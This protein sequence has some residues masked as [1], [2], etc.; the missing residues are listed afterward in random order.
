[1]LRIN[2]SIALDVELNGNGTGKHGFQPGDPQTGR[3]PTQVPYQWLNMLQEEI[4]NLLE[5]CGVALNAAKKDQLLD[6][7][8][9]SVSVQ[10]QVAFF[11][12]STA[13]T[14]WLKANG[15]AISRT[16]YAA[17]FA[18]IGATFGAGDG[19]TTFNLPDLRGQFPRGWDDGRGVDAGRAF[20]SAQEGTWLRTMMQEWTGSDTKGGPFNIG[21]S[22]A[23]NDAILNAGVAGLGSPNPVGAKSAAGNGLNSAAGDNGIQGTAVDVTDN[24]GA[25]VNTWIRMR[26]TNVALL[27]CIKY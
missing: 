21:M 9:P 15:A 22:Y 3:E 13:P 23:Q 27:A 12:R 6:L 17:L 1:M 20:G 16:T 10:G 14:G 7:L 25:N 19:S 18:A 26:P 2:P 4:A 8:K 5:G 11:A 24:S